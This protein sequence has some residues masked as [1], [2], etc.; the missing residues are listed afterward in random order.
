M[1]RP[2]RPPADPGYLYPGPTEF[3]APKGTKG[4]RDGA[5]GSHFVVSVVGLGLVLL[6]TGTGWVAVGVRRAGCEEDPPAG[7]S[8]GHW[9][10][11]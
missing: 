8:A 7:R 5:A 2:L 6:E 11:L 3:G 9:V 1:G 4:S 10:A